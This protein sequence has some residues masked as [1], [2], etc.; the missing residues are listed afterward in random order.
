MKVRFVYTDEGHPWQTGHIVSLRVMNAGDLTALEA[1]RLPAALYDENN[2]G[3]A[4][5][6]SITD[7]IEITAQELREQIFYA[8][9]KT[10]NPKTKQLQEVA[11]TIR[12]DNALDLAAREE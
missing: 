7:A 4:D 6:C 12:R 10:V 2:L 11:D 1:E 5:G 8:G 9:V 3:I